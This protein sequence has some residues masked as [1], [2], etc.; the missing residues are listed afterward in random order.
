MS[1]GALRLEPT[2][3]DGEAVIGV[4]HVELRRQK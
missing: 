2:V 4:R 3:T 1:G